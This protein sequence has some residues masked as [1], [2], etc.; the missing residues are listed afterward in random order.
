M[1]I[2][3][4]ISRAISY[5]VNEVIVQGLANNHSFQRFAVR[6][7][8][9]LEDVAQMAA[10]T[11]QGLNEKTREIFENIDSTRRQ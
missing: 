2:G 7:S 8:K 10:K 9:K 11:R 4:L 3:N 1:A 5:A 6:T